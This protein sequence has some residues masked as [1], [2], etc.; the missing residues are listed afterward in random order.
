MEYEQH[1]RELIGNAIAH[2]MKER[3]MGKERLERESGVSKTI[4]YKILRGDNYEI[5]SLIRVMRILQ[6]HIELSLMS[7]DN[8]VITM[9]NSLSKN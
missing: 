4:I 5:T 9:G 3:N 2:C 6:V 1:A 8:N 7:G